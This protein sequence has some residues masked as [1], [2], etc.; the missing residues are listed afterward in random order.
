MRI[1]FTASADSAVVAATVAGTIFC[2][3]LAALLTVC[4]TRLQ[5][6]GIRAALLFAAGML[7][8]LPIG[9]YLFRPLE[10]RINDGTLVVVRSIG[11]VE[12]PLSSIRAAE[13]VSRVAPSAWRL[14]GSSGLFGVFGWFYT[15]EL[16]R[17]RAYATRFNDGLVVRTDSGP[18]MLTPDKR[19]ELA[20]VLTQSRRSD[21]EAPGRS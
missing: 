21:N 7:A 1:Q 19:E 9:A 15:S 3:G 20:R 17:Y 11:D 10:Y 14:F 8:L 13:P 12:I 5:L 2:L 6:P 4:A 16:G 18:I